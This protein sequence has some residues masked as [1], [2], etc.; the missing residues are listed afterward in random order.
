MLQEDRRHMGTPEDSVI[1][2]KQIALLLVWDLTNDTA[3]IKLF[4]LVTER[5]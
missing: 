3:K 5:G 1:Y 2:R 4:E